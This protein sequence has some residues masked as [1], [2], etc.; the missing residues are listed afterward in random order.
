MDLILLFLLFVLISGFGKT[1]NAIKT[2]N[3]KLNLHY[4]QNERM[5]GLLTEIKEE[6]KN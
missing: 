5:I 6:L 3:S 1:L 4:D 2:L